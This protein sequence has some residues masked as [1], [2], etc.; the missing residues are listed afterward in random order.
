MQ[1]GVVRARPNYLFDPKSRGRVR[2]VVLM[3][4]GGVNKPVFRRVMLI[5][6]RDMLVVGMQWSDPLT[7]AY[8]FQYVEDNEAYTVLSH[9]YTH[10]KRAVIADGITLANGKLELMP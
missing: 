1:E 10:D 5:R 9:D 2:G 8:D 6:E 3:H 7:G 4:V